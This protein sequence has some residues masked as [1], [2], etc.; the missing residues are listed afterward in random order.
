MQIAITLQAEEAFELTHLSICSHNHSM[1]PLFVV[2]FDIYARDIERATLRSVESKIEVA[3]SMAISI[4][5]YAKDRQQ[6]FPFVTLP[7]FEARA[8]KAMNLSQA[9]TISWA[10]LVDQA[11][12]QAWENYTQYEAP[13]WLRNRLDYLG[14][15]DAPI[16]VFAPFIHDGAMNRVDGPYFTG[17]E[18]LNGKYSPRW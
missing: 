6:E 10:P 4:T 8:Q 17:N 9:E 2:Q 15:D 7:D 12:R 5:S 14:L 18:V 1:A 13:K 16:P 11:T 3:R